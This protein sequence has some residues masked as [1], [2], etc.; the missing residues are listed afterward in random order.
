MLFI[1]FYNN[2]KVLWLKGGE[3]V[4]YYIHDVLYRAS[5]P[6]IHLLTYIQVTQNN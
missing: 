3:I 4:G 6:W 5:I 1:F 2:M